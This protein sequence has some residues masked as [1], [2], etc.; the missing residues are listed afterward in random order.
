MEPK[1]KRA[2]KKEQTCRWHGL[3]AQWNV[4]EPWINWQFLLLA[5][6]TL[7]EKCLRLTNTAKPLKTF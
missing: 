2:R 4:G 5:K 6:D 7:S 1:A 3:R